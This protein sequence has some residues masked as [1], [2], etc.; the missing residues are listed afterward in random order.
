[1]LPTGCQYAV[2][3]FVKKICIDELRYSWPKTSQQWEAVC[4]HA[5]SILVG[6]I[7][8]AVVRQAGNHAY[9]RV[10]NNMIHLD[11]AP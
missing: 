9:S 3:D 1:V 11:H 6:F 7:Q 2:T 5:L 8:V 10:A 4:L